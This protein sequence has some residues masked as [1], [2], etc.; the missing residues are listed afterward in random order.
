MKITEHGFLVK[1]QLPGIIYP[2][3]TIKVPLQKYDCTRKS[4]H[5][6]LYKRQLGLF[7]HQ[8]FKVS[9]LLNMTFW[10]RGNIYIYLLNNHGVI[11]EVLKTH[12]FH[13]RL[14]GQGA[15]VFMYMDVTYEV[16]N[17]KYDWT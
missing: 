12:D 6:V 10:S 7:S 16:S 2:D 9:R 5:K 8:T 13:R 1:R 17:Q 4:L 15:I 14:F 11:V 3:Q